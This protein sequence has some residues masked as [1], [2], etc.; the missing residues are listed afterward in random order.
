M[1]YRYIAA[2]RLSRQINMFWDANSRS[3]R[4]A[5]KPS[6]AP[7]AS[8]SKTSVGPRRPNPSKMGILS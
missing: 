6:N 7:M 2:A 8:A 1:P 4:A 3:F 5:F